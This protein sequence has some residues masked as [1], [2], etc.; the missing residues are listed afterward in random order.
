MIN[1]LSII[2]TGLLLSIG[3]GLVAAKT[4]AAGKT[5]PL[6]PLS[7]R[8]PVSRAVFPPGKGS[9]IANTYC[10]MCHSVGMV[11]RQPPLTFKAWKAE[12]NKMRTAYGAPIPASDVETIARYLTT[13]NGPTTKAAPPGVMHQQGH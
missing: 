11:T 1:Q 6:H 7:V 2:V 13:I 12:V 3:A 5:V 4:T 9:S 10:V 8:P